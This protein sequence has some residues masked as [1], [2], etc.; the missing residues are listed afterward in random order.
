MNLDEIILSAHGFAEVMPEHK[1]Q[2]V[3]RLREQ[4]HVTGMTGE[5]ARADER[6]RAGCTQLVQH[7]RANVLTYSSSFVPVT[8]QVSRSTS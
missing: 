1:F 6:V 4:G 2:I 3:Q 8:S 7:R 5:Q